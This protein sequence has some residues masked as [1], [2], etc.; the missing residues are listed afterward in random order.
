[1]NTCKIC[2]HESESEFFN[3]EIGICHSCSLIL[4]SKVNALQHA[5]STF[6]EKVNSSNDTDEK[7]TYLKLILDY[8]YEYKILYYDNDVDVLEQDVDDLISD[9]IDCIADVRV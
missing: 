8:L 6:Q 2:N 1:M 9:I 3:D 5:V 7:I 4:E